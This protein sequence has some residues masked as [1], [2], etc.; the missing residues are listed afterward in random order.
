MCMVLHFGVCV[1]VCV[2]EWDAIG[3]INTTVCVLWFICTE[4][5]TR[6]QILLHSF[7]YTFTHCVHLH[8]PAHT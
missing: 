5:S 7:V 4:L 1:F 2:M 6:A 3:R 8:T